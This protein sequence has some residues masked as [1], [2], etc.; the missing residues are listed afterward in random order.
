MSQIFEVVI[1]AFLL[2]ISIE[3]LLIYREV[4]RSQIHGRDTKEEAESAVKSGQTI[5]VT[6]AGPSGLPTPSPAVSLGPENAAKGSAG[7]SAPALEAP[8]LKQSPE[9]IDDRYGQAPQ[10][11]PPRSAP[12]PRPAT[13]NPFAKACPSCGMENSNYRTECFNCGTSL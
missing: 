5:N 1:I 12:A 7:A 6:V 4:I 8:A 9:G 13:G 11:A 10:S 2:L 3:L